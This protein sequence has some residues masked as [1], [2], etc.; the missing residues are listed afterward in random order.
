MK[1]SPGGPGADRV[2]PVVLHL[3]TRKRRS[4]GRPRTET[5]SP[6]PRP[7]SPILNQLPVTPSSLS[8]PSDTHST[9]MSPAP[10]DPVISIGRPLRTHKPPSYLKDYHVSIARS[11]SSSSTRQGSNVTLLQSIKARLCGQFHTKDLGSLKYFLGIEVARSSRGLYLCQRKY[12]LDILDDCGL[13]GARPSEFPMEQNLKLSNSTGAILSDPS[14]YRRLVGRLIYLT[15]TRPDIVHTVNILSQFMHQ[16]QQPHL[17]AAHRLIH[18]LKG[19]PGQGIFLHSQS[20]LALKAF[21]DSDWASCPMTRRSTTG[22][23]IFLGSS[24]ISW[25]TKKQTTVSRSSAE[26]EYRSMAVATCE[27]TWL[28]FLLRDLGMPL[29]TPVPLYCDNQA[30]LHIAA[31]P[32]FHERS[33]QSNAWRRL[34]SASSTIVAPMDI[35]GQPRRPTPKG[36]SSK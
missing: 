3:G 1:G 8:P 28:S 6:S 4:I 12:T 9:P 34:A 36:S 17:D 20:D 25:K 5:E 13:T 30:A 10:N 26:A 16:P 7:T 32:I 29:T 27:I 15:V 18:Y 31:N 24:P 11:N 22:Y 35:P 33:S 21:Y 2:P 23:C 14:P 19:S